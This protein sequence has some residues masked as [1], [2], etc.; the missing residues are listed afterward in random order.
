MKPDTLIEGHEGDYRMQEPL[1]ISPV[2]TELLSF[3]NFAIKSLS[4]AYLWKY[5]RELNETWF[6]D[7]WPSEEVQSAGKGAWAYVCPY[8]VNSLSYTLDKRLIVSSFLHPLLK[9][10]F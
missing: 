10:T 3:F 6:I 5:R 7:R 8:G 1:T 2:F 9:I 4:G